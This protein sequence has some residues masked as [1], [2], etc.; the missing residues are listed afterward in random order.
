[1]STIM[2]NWRLSMSSKGLFLSDQ[3]APFTL[4]TAET[5]F[6]IQKLH[7]KTRYKLHQNKIKMLEKKMKPEELV[8]D[9]TWKSPE[10]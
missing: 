1:M 10:L 6:S 4:S 7:T 3:E 2:A 9:T 8:E 5:R